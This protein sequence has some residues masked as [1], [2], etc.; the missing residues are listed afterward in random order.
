MADKIPMNPDKIL[1][2][3]DK[4]LKIQLEGLF[5][6][7]EETTTNGESASVPVNQEQQ[8]PTPQL[9]GLFS[10]PPPL[11][12][13]IT[14]P[15]TSTNKAKSP[16]QP[17]VKVKSQPESQL[18]RFLETKVTEKSGVDT[19]TRISTEERLLQLLKSTDVGHRRR[20]VQRLTQ[21]QSKWSIDPLLQAAADSDAEVATLAL[22]ALLQL[23][24]VA[25]R[26]VLAMAQHPLAPLL[27]Q[28]SEAY[29]SHLLGQSFVY[30][31]YGSFLMG[32]HPA[33]DEL[34]N[35]NEQ[36]QH[37][38]HLTGYWISRYPVT[39]ARYRAFATEA[40]HPLPDNNHQQ[41]ADD[42][43]MVD[44]TWYDALAYCHWLSQRSGLRVTLPSEAEWE[45]AARG[46]DG[47]RYPWGNQQPT[48]ELCN[49]QHSTPVGQ[50]SP[51]G[52]SPHGCADMVGNVWEWTRS[53][54]KPYPYN[55]RDGRENMDIKDS[56]VIRGL[57]S[58]NAK[59]FTRCAFR[60]SLMPQLHLGH[61]GFRVIVSPS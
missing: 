8:N 18:S 3:P 39:E 25:K 43:P 31:P 36:P 60:Y 19:A 28:G 53:V 15:A 23:D 46:T 26:R 9:E 50:Y 10:S 22:A 11:V 57:T 1:A 7:L 42:Y 61:L 4:N 2:K 29:L 34:A 21:I 44:V 20:A 24:D 33:T 48:S 5:S 52:D 30:I 56:R 55:P 6:D 58:N 16:E 59:R 41:A 38:I 35:P 51:Q 47:R 13:A 17:P 32:S 54:Y 14:P 37:V 49:L 27:H 12:K 40:N 45:K